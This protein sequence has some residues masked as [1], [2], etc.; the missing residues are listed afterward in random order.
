MGPPRASVKGVRGR[1]PRPNNEALPR[2]RRRRRVQNPR[3]GC[4]AAHPHHRRARRGAPSRRRGLR[5]RRGRQE[6]PDAASRRGSARP[7][8]SDCDPGCGLQRPLTGAHGRCSGGAVR[9]RQPQGRASADQERDRRLLDG[10][11]HPGVGGARVRE[12]GARRVPYVARHEGVRSSQRDPRGLRVGC[13]RS[14]DVRSA[15]G[16]GAD[17]PV[18]RIFSD[19]SASLRAGREPRS[20]S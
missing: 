10:L 2:H 3:A 15:T 14:A 9:S 17:R 11:A 6:H 7:R 16:G 13:A 8:A 12:R 4:R 18:P 20:C 19:P 1:S 5:Q